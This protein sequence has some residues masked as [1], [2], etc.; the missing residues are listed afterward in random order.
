MNDI[1]VR[2]QGNPNAG[3]SAYKQSIE[4]LY[5]IAFTIKMSKKG[6]RHIEGDF[7]C[8]LPSI[9]GFWWQDGRIYKAF[10]HDRYA[11]ILFLCADEIADIRP[12]AGKHFIVEILLP[13]DIGNAVL[14]FFNSDTQ[15]L[16]FFRQH[17]FSQND[18]RFTF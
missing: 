18:G 11:G 5:G 17:F 14:Q 13:V 4:L 1:A 15:G 7:D 12:L 6:S 10:V 3:N 2:R 16:L 8:V 9:G